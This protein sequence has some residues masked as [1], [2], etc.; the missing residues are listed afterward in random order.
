MVSHQ[1]YSSFHSDAVDRAVLACDLWEDAAQQ[2]L[3]GSECHSTAFIR[4]AQRSFSNTLFL[5]RLLILGCVNV[6]DTQ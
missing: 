4:D 2:G 1:L 6:T 3:H 5:L